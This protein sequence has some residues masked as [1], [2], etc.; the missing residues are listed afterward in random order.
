MVRRPVG[1][2]DAGAVDAE[3]DRQV[4]ERDLLEDLVVRALEERAVDVDHRPRAGLGHAASHRDGVAL[5]DA[6]VEELLR[7]GL[8]HLLE[9]V[10][11]AH[12][13]RQHGD[14]R[15]AGAGVEQGGGEGVGVGLVAGDLQRDDPLLGLLERVRR[16]ELHR[17]LHG[18][19]EA[20]ALVG[21]DVE[22]DRPAHRLDPLQV[23]PQAL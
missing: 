17:I 8:A 1:P 22:Q 4:L 12:R 3:D 14:L 21:Q 10:P 15:V 5:A 16:V 23:R 7:E 19:L 6:D 20:V 11:L 13:G 9:L 18:R 2:H